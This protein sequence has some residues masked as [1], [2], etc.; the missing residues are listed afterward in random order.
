MVGVGEVWLKRFKGTGGAMIE[1]RTRK[2]TRGR[3]PEIR[4]AGARFGIINSRGG[5][6]WNGWDI[7]VSGNIDLRGWG[8][9]IERR[10]KGGKVWTPSQKWS[11]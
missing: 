6:I 4:A 10:A 2:G 8:A 7:L 3:K 11:R 5:G 1:R 9:A